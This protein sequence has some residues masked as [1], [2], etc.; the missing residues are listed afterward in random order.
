[1]EWPR[2][3]SDPSPP[4]TLEPPDRVDRGPTRRSFLAAVGAA[5]VAGA[6]RREPPPFDASAFAVPA[7][8]AVGLFAAASYSAELADVIFR[9]FKELGVSV[10]G[11]RVF[12]K[13]NMVEYEPGTSINTHPHVVAGTAIACRRA[14]AAEVVVGEGPGHRRDIEYLL[15]TTGLYDQLKEHGIRFVDLNHDDV[16][17]VPLKS[18]FTGLRELALPVELLR[19]DFVISLPK[20]KT[21]HWAGMTCSMKNLFGV[22]PGAVYGWPKNILH[23]RSIP[24]SILD[25][26]STVRPHL[27]VVDAITAMEGDGPIMGKPRALGFLAMGTDLPAVDAT[28]ARIIGLDPDKL[29][30]LGPAGQFLGNITER[31]IEQ[32]GEPPSRYATRF[33]V[34]PELEFL[35]LSR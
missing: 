35:R 32:R 29:A 7:R 20:L 23:M 22:V 6:C 10:A 16:R 31:R 33:E 2:L 4:S 21:H 1:M 12:L 19:S 13:P 14:G 26:T 34:V 3:S 15:A 11:R 25:L 17:V 30:Y 28:C 5:V 9:G 8:S 18:W 27:T 24:A